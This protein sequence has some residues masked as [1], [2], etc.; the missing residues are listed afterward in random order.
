[1]MG[2]R[3]A[4]W[5]PLA[6]SATLLFMIGSNVTAVIWWPLLC[7]ITIPIASFG[8]CCALSAVHECSH[9]TYLSNRSANEFVGRFFSL[10][11]CVNFS[12]YR[13]SHLLHHKFLGTDRDT[14]PRLH[15]QTRWQLIRA[16][17]CNPHMID[18]WRETVVAVCGSDLTAS[19]RRRRT[20][21]VCVLLVAAAA[22][23]ACAV[24]P[25]MIILGYF[26][27]YLLS[28]I[29]D[30]LVSIPEHARFDSDPQCIT[31][32]IKAGLF[33]AWLLYWVNDHE[34]HHAGNGRSQIEARH[35]Q[36]AVRISYWQ[37]FLSAYTKL[38]HS[39]SAALL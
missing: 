35:Q 14:E 32:S 12:I 27:P 37:F 9:S 19:A 1:M 23:V 5:V 10:I 26:A 6:H 39:K 2:F 7:W 3:R 29:F 8:L 33:M 34:N 20:D 24:A 28:L 22:V 13:R 31:R 18:H 15:I 25:I 21:G 17:L 16:I 30:N 36:D 4:D 38:K 11:I